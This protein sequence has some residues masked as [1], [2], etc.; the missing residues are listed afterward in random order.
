LI[1]VVSELAKQECAEMLKA[2]LATGLLLSVTPALAQTQAADNSQ[3]TSK[4]ATNPDKVIC[5]SQQQIG[6]RIATKKV[7]MTAQQW[8]EHAAQI[9]QQLDSEHVGTQNAGSPGG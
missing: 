8:K 6:S 5:E 1:Y 3:Q 2:V 9:R 4:P 7:C